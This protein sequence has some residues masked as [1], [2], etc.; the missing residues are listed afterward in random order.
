MAQA[1]LLLTY[2]V[3]LNPTAAQHCAMDAARRRSQ[4]IYNAALEERIGAYR[5]SG[6]T[7]TYIDQCKGLTEVR[8]DGTPFPVSMERWPLKRLDLAFKA[9][10]S[11]AQNGSNPGFP[12]FKSYERWRSFGF[13]QSQGWSLSGGSLL[14]KGIGAIRCKQH[15]ALPSAPCSLVVRRYGRRWFACFGVRVQSGSN[16]TGET[17][18]LDLGVS[19][20]ATLSNGEFIAN[21]NVAKRRASRIKRAQRALARCKAKSNGRRKVKQKLA[22]LREREAA[23]RLTY[24]HQVTAHLAARFGKIVI[25]DLKPANMVRSARGS[26]CA[27]GNGVAQKV[28]L[29]RSLSDA[30]FGKFR[31]LLTYK[32]ARAGG[33]VVAVDPKYTSQTCS[34]CGVVDAA[35]RKSQSRFV[36]TGCG[37]SANADVNAALNIARRGGGIVPGGHNV[38]RLSH[39]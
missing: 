24:L 39:A 17:V 10:F 36:C 19:R 20:L 5:K 16:H 35:S 34:A 25:E 4:Q 28:G 9:F 12:R 15:R 38:G 7:R 26:K 29:N 33:Q 27:P 1:A 2:K 23:H 14:I 31:E 22:R 32:A 6:I 13:T 21:A 18:G 3:R 8:A 37:H 11:R 30:A